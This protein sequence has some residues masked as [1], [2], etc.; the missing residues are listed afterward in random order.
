MSDDSEYRKGTD[1]RGRIAEAQADEADD[2]ACLAEHDPA[3][4]A[5]EL[6]EAGQLHSVDQRRPQEFESVAEADPGQ[7][8]DGREVDPGIAEPRIERPDQQ[9][10]GKPG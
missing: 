4:A 5:A 1:R 10:E 7:D 3:L 9:C 8:A 6:T 2:Q